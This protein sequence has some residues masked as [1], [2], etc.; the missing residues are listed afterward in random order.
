MKKR[1]D[2]MGYIERE[3]AIK[4]VCDSS[5]HTCDLKN[6][7]HECQEAQAIL[8]IPAADV[9]PVE[10]GKW[11][12]I[13]KYDKESPVQWSACLADFSFIDGVGWLCSGYELPLFC[14]NCG[15]RMDGESE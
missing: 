11:I 14:P 10:R 4:A 15:A 2:V 9:R 7:F 6:C 12:R 5:P 8:A 1:G 13:D 3:A